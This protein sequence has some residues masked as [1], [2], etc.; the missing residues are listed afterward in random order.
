MTPVER[1]ELALHSAKPVLAL[2]AF[3]QELASE[4]NSKP[5]IQELLEN[6]LIS[7][8]TRPG[9]SEAD[10]DALMDVLDALA[11]WCHPSAELLP[12]KLGG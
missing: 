10:E 12:E 2:R 8:R 6:A 11:G 9:F 1:A 7:L 3:V 5:A 4:G